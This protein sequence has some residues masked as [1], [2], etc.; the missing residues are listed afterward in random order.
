LVENGSSDASWSVAQDLVGTRDGVE[1][2]AYREP[3][4]GL[5]YA[6]DRGVREVLESERDPGAVFVALTASDLPFGFS[7]LN[8][9]E[10][11]HLANP[12]GRIAIGSKAHRESVVPTTPLRTV[13]TAVFRAARL[14][15]IGMR[16]GDS[17]GTFFVR[18][19]LLAQHHAKIRARDYF[20]TTELVYFVERA[21]EP[22][23]EL[24]V[25]MA[26]ARRPS[27]VRP[28]KHGGR[29]LRALLELRARSG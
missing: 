9:F 12:S 8:A 14:A 13:M 24:P 7:D 28:F 21:G 29:M 10:R 15:L 1:I 17:Q 2:R 19:D 26:P 3:S 27:T 6:L 18:A 16:T 5:G 11:W 22:I 4:A 20:W 23:E 25:R